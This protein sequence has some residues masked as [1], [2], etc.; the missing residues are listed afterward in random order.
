[1]ESKER[2]LISEN[3]RISGM[4]HSSETRKRTL[5]E[6]VVVVSTE[7]VILQEKIDDS[8]KSLATLEA[9]LVE[10]QART[11]ALQ[12]TIAG[13]K[14]GIKR[15]KSTTSRIG[16]AFNSPI[17]SPIV[18]PIGSPTG[19]SIGSPIGSPPVCPLG[20]PKSSHRLVT[21]L[22]EA[23]EKDIVLVNEVV[24]AH[25]FKGF[26]Y[27]AFGE[28]STDGYER[29]YFQFPATSNSSETLSKRKLQERVH[30][31]EKC[32]EI[33]SEGSSKTEFYAELMNLNHQTFKEAIKESDIHLNQLTAEDTVAIQSLFRFSDNTMRKLRVCFNNRKV[34]IFASERQ[35]KK[36]KEPLISH[37]KNAESGV[38][39][40]MRTKNDENVSSCAFVRIPLMKKFL[41]DLIEKDVHTFDFEGNFQNRW[42][43]LFAGDKGGRHMKYTV[44]IENSSNAGSVNNV[45]VYAMFEA[46]DS[47]ENML[48][49]WFPVYH[50]Q[51]QEMQSEEFTMNDG[52]KVLIFLGGDY[53]YLDDNMGHQGS[54]A[55][56]PSALDKVELSHLQNHGGK[57]HTPETCPVEP[58][59]IDDYVYNYNE[60]LAD[61][62]NPND[63]RQNGKF[64][65]SVVG[66]MMFPLNSLIQ[67]VPPSLHVLLGV[68][69]VLYNL[70]Q[71]ACRKIDCDA[72]NQEKCEAEKERINLD[73]EVASWEVSTIEN[74]LNEIGVQVL[75]MINRKHRLDAVLRGDQKTNIQL[76]KSSD[77]S[78]K[79]C[80][81]N[82]KCDSPVCIITNY[83]TN[84][85]WV[86]CDICSPDDEVNLHTMC[87][88][89]TPAEENSLGDTSYSCIKCRNVTMADVVD[90]K[91]QQLLADEQSTTKRKIESQVVADN[92]KS[93]Y[94]K[95]LGDREKKLELALEHMKVVRQAY[96]GNVM[97]GNHSK[98]VLER[99]KELTEVIADHPELKAKFDRLFEIFGEAMRYTMARRFL[100][101][102]EIEKLEELV[103][104]FGKLFPVYFPERYITRKIHELIFNFVPF[105]KKSKTIGLLSEQESESKHAAVNAALRM[106]A[107]VRNHA[108]RI[109][110]V[111]EREEMRALTDKSIV[112]PVS[113]LCKSGHCPPR[114]FLRAGSDGMPHCKLC[115]RSFFD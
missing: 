108:E 33:A 37:V 46:Q 103:I 99:H 84:I 106:T 28:R 23:T 92:L 41:E 100:L 16:S 2:Q 40:L 60:F 64:H 21:E 95:F 59:D 101:E 6:D 12:N 22:K 27:P 65:C 17:G 107:C 73:W 114:T 55:S 85:E 68:T 35:T 102:D 75:I 105:A 72:G 62:R 98:I 90:S 25:V 110:L 48:K 26:R 5:E 44:E 81:K 14:S 111:L 69:L 51:L 80:T 4:L 20:S 78:A 97:V 70:L 49:F 112:T 63:R 86:A 39:G 9:E 53:H 74:T 34:P 13:L 36:V 104:E 113:R 18:S 54:S 19:S 58:R 42:W 52:R 71:D 47:V 8:V 50:D 61:T 38:M 30:L 115:E 79:K 11:K 76:M 1:M 10:S 3:R 93:A 24:D 82:S 15:R 109:K 45:H 91:I 57:P 88:G 56:Y 31:I 7:N 87:Q 94:H 96:H 29:V 77:I 43:F 67:V 89:L 66:P 32:V 83:D